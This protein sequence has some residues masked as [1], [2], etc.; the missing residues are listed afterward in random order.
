MLALKLNNGISP[1][2]RLMNYSQFF[3]DNI[4]EGS[5]VLDIGCGFG[6]V[7]SKLAE[8]AREVVAIDKSESA[9]NIA[10]SKYEKQNIKYI[11]GDATM[12]QF[13]QYFDYIVL[14]NVLEHIKNRKEFLTKI[15]PLAKYFLIRVPMI[16]RSWL[17]LYKKELGL[18]YRLD[19]SHHIE[20]TYNSFKD[21]IESIGLKIVQSTVQ[22]GEIWAK[23]EV[24]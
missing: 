1:K 14:S 3:L 4:H 9:I 21:E 19:K 18:E 12:Y 11:Y 17:P 23:V 15:K 10:R 16:N 8:K 20:Y 22:F 2:H 24:K 5:L 6:I 13:N 7:S